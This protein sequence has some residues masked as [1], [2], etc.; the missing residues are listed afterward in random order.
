MSTTSLLLVALVCAIV[1]WAL[2]L[3]VPSTGG[4]VAAG[5]LALLSTG[6]GGGIGMPY[7]AKVGVS[8]TTLAGWALFVGGLALLVASAIVLARGVHGWTRLGVVVCVV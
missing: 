5:C 2:L 6:I 7:A 4:R 3:L 1:G 8:V